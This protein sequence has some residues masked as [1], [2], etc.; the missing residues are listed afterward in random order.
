MN[1]YAAL[2]NQLTKSARSRLRYQRLGPKRRLL[3]RLAAA[4]GF[5]WQVQ[6]NEQETELYLSLLPWWHRAKGRSRR[7]RQRNRRRF[8]APLVRQATEISDNSSS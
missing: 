8:A 1:Q 7:I 5:G 6:L 3:L 4:R 2:Q